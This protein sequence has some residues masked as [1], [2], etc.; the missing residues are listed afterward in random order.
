MPDVRLRVQGKDYAGWKRIRFGHGIETLCGSF[1]L[2]VSDRW[3][4]QSKPWPIREEDECALMVDGLPV[5]TGYVD[6]CSPSYGPKDHSFAVSGRDKT[7]ALVDCS[8]DLGKWEFTNVSLKAFAEK[9]CEPFGI[10]VLVQDRL[11]FPTVSR[12]SIDPGE[13]CFEAIE[14]ACRM[15]GALPVSDLGDL[16][17]TRAGEGRA[18]TDLVEGENIL[19]ASGEYD[20]SSRFRTYK[21]LGQHRGADDFFG[22]TAAAAKGAAEDTG[23]RRPERALV[24]RADGNATSAQAKSRAQWEAIV[25]AAR[26]QAVSVTVQGW[27]QGDGSLWPVNSMVRVKSPF[28]GIDSDML[29]RQATFS[30]DDG[31]TTTE[32]QLGRPDA[33]RP[34]PTVKPVGKAGGK[35]GAP[36]SEIARGV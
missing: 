25:R 24:L 35:G 1:D 3:A 29:I 8:A 27:T 31:G 22:A 20:A 32:L 19:S 17:F 14:R 21:V 15:V 23:V 28:L 16:R 36:W 10:A 6:K 9:I 5:I 4:G 7:S 30:L 18:V 33:Y 2:S 13:T 26:A 12:L 11:S 34:E